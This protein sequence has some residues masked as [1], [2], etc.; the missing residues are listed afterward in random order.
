LPLTITRA[1]LPPRS[2]P[3]PGVVERL[4]ARVG[5]FAG[6]RFEQDVIAGARVEGRIEIDEIDRGIGD[7]FAKD[8]KIIAIEE[9]VHARS[10]EEGGGFDK[11]SPNGYW[12]TAR[13]TR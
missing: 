5:A 4:D 2:P 10:V 3:A 11:L 12:R 8:V 9:L 7:M 13:V 6:R 1:A